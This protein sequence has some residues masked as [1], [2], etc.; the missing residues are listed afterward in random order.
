MKSFT[1]FSLMILLFFSCKESIE[2]EPETIKKLIVFNTDNSDL[3]SNWIHCIAIDNSGNK[4]IGTDDGLVKFD[5]INWTIYNTENSGLPYNEINTLLIE[6]EN[7]I[8][9][10]T[11]GGLVMFDGNNWIVYDK[12]NS[13]IP[14]NYILIVNSDNNGSIWFGIIDGLAKFDGTNW[15]VYD[16]LYG[17]HITAIH[18]DENDNIWIGTEG[19][20]GNRRG[21]YKY[22]GSVWKVYDEFTSD[23]Y[24]D[25]IK[26]ILGDEMNTL[27]LGTDKALIHFIEP[28]YKLFYLVEPTSLWGIR[29]LVKDQNGTI[30]ISSDSYESLFVKFE[31][32]NFTYYDLTNLGS[33]SDMITSIAVDEFNNKWIATNTK[34]IIVFNEEGVIQY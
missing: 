5:G 10:G 7:R 2:P 34:G 15:T 1:L 8:W 11:G 16:E 31:S 23:Y 24:C 6:S 25:N 33:P 4:W 3:P 19:T 29:C 12:S 32:F 18:A 28:R 20:I 13:Q 22:D 9:I 21:F 14:D 30:W 27:W 17:A 26:C